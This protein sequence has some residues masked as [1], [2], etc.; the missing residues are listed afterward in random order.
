MGCGASSNSP[1]DN[2]SAAKPNETTDAA[3]T[4]SPGSSDCAKHVAQLSGTW[5]I[6]LTPEQLAG[7]EIKVKAYREE[8]AVHHKVV[9]G[10]FSKFA[11]MKSE[12]MSDEATNAAEWKVLE[13]AAANSQS[14]LTEKRDEMV[15]VLTL[16][17]QVQVLQYIGSKKKKEW[18]EVHHTSSLGL[19]PECAQIKAVPDMFEPPP[20]TGIKQHM[21][22][23][24]KQLG[25]IGTTKEQTSKILEYVTNYNK[26]AKDCAEAVDAELQSM[27]DDRAASVKIQ[28]IRELLSVC[29][30]N[31]VDML[32][33]VY[34][35]LK[36]SQKF[37]VA[38]ITVEDGYFE[39]SQLD[40]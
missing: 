23:L 3:A 39:I 30:K 37:A 11:A 2:T 26:Q 28:R 9:H 29:F 14:K 24:K 31:R 36:P 34:G 21:W 22:Y 33:H 15:A 10:L 27:G 13:D 40:C 7:L 18:E 32:G 17:D 20:L 38:K 1:E 8:F 25:K 19:A 6:K 12:S 5:G 35:E 4:A 16:E